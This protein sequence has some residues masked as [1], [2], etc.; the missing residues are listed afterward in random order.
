[1]RGKAERCSGKNTGMRI[2]RL[3][4]IMSGHGYVQVSLGDSFGWPGTLGHTAGRLGELV[5]GPYSPSERG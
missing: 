3:S 1:M 2:I 4:G 5:N